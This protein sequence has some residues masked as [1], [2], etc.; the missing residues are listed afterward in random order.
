MER[1][2]SRILKISG[3]ERTVD[4]TDWK[5]LP[6]SW[7]GSS[8]SSRQLHASTNSVGSNGKLTDGVDEDRLLDALSGSNPVALARVIQELRA[9]L[10]Q[11]K[12]DYKDLDGTKR[13]ASGLCKM[14]TSLQDY[15]GFVEATD[16]KP[17]P[18]YAKITEW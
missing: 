9:Q 1:S 12:K 2:G 4:T 8:S 10:E 11:H 3:S 5:P 17:V 15:L 13:L 16:E 6:L 14:L 18:Y 7:S